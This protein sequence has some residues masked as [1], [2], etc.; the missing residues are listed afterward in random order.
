MIEPTDR[1]ETAH[2]GIKTAITMAIIGGIIGLVIGLVA[3]FV[4]KEM[5]W[6]AVA[7]WLAFVGLRAIRMVETE[8]QHV[9]WR[10]NER[11]SASAASVR[12]E[13]A[14][15]EAQAKQTRVQTAIAVQHYKHLPAG[16]SA[17][18]APINERKSSAWNLRVTINYG[19]TRQHVTL[20]GR[21]VEAYVRLMRE[22]FTG[23]YRR[24]LRDE[25]LTFENTDLTLIRQLLI[26]HGV[27][28]G[29]NVNRE[30]LANVLEMWRT[31]GTTMQDA[32]RAREMLALS[33]AES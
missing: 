10:E 30:Q 13:A 5:A 14:Q 12:A 33:P 2:T 7:I 18:T 4:I 23:D 1:A 15:I 3:S 19:T 28:E 21:L 8:R 31:T 6:A 11:V 26:E 27:V 22:G 24:R 9:N 32:A 20:P 17:A 29:K 25:G 16:V